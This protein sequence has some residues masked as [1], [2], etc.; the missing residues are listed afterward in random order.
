VA[1]QVQ[2]QPKQP[3]PPQRKIMR[4]L[5]HELYRQLPVAIADLCDQVLDSPESSNGT[6]NLMTGMSKLMGFRARWKARVE[7]LGMEK[8]AEAKAQADEIRGHMKIVDKVI[9]TGHGNIRRVCAKLEKLL[10]SAA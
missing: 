8:T 9:R 3:V 10:P 7:K 6:E 2:W 4:N 5:P 1:K